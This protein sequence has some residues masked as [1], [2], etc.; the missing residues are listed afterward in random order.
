[1]AIIQDPVPGVF[2][3][4][5]NEDFTKVFIDLQFFIFLLI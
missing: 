4:P 3:I 2:I 1:M 5:D